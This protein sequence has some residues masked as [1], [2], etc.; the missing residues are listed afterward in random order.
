[1]S[2]LLSPEFHNEEAAFKH[3]ESIVWPNG[4]CCPHCGGVERLIRLKSK[5][6]RAGLWE[7]CKCRKQ[8]TAKI[9]TFLEYSHLPMTKWLQA[10]YLM[11]SSKT[12]IPAY[13]LCRILE[14]QY[15]T[16]WFIAR[17]LRK[18]M[19]KINHGQ[20]KAK[21]ELLKESNKNVKKQVVQVVK[22]RAAVRELTHEESEESY[23]A[24]L[25]RVAQQKPMLRSAISRSRRRV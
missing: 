21:A 14:T 1:M 7:C 17:H 18:A 4:P 10:V 11:A 8:F 15:N 24:L 25:L 3:F 19:R 5:S 23:D 13:R 20:A 2:K 9:G 22:F 16:A 12:D 6:V